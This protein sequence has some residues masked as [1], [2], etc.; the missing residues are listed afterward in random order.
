[1]A[2]PVPADEKPTAPADAPDQDAQNQF[3]YSYG[4]PS[5]G[6]QY[7]GYPYY[8]GYPALKAVAGNNLIVII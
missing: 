5:Y 3:L 8:A 1:M 2:T 6:Y 4:Y 7:A